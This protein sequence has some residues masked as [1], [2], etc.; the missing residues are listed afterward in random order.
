MTYNEENLPPLTLGPLVPFME[1]FTT[2]EWV[3]AQG[4][5]FT[6]NPELGAYLDAEGRVI[7]LEPTQS[8]GTLTTDAYYE[9]P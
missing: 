3:E 5:R 6:F 8:D 9:L 1:D 7:M 4:Q 2:P